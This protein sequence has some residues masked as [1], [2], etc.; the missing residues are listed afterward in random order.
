MCAWWWWWS[1]GRDGGALRF[2]GG[3]LSLTPLILSAPER[4]W[5]AQMTHFVPLSMPELSVG[6][7]EESRLL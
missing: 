1:G 4:Q 2:G 7:G 5:R 6:I 3:Q